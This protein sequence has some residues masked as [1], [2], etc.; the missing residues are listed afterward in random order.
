MRKRLEGDMYV[1]F[2]RG[3]RIVGR[4]PIY[5]EFGV[6]VMHVGREKMP[7]SFPEPLPTEY[8]EA[9]K[10]LSMFMLLI[11]ASLRSRTHP[12]CQQCGESFERREPN[13]QFCSEE[14]RRAYYKAQASGNA[15]NKQNAMK[16]L[17]K[18]VKDALKRGVSFK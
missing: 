16:K 15:Q 13:V 9:A 5:P 2:K 10:I 7:I 8:G 12:E 6:P 11:E 14:C 17:R 4:L 18:T 3:R 1:V